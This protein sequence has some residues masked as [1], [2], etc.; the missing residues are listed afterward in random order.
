MC[1]DGAVG[2]VRGLGE[3]VGIGAGCVV[4]G[5]RNR[6]LF[7]IAHIYVAHCRHCCSL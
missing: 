1:F 7:L 5:A 3:G 6:R 4:A 2:A